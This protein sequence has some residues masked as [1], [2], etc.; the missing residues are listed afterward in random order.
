MGYTISVIAE[1]ISKIVEF[2]IIGNKL[3]SEQTE[4]IRE[5]ENLWKSYYILEK[6]CFI[7]QTIFIVFV[8]ILL[9]PAPNLY[10]LEEN[11][12]TL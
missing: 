12:I 9:R 3:F 7:I 6:S 11:K 4:T 10:Y 8:F 1:L 2:S 5:V